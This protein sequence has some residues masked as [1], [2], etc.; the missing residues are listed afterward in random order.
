MNLLLEVCNGELKRF[1]ARLSPSKEKYIFNGHILLSIHSL[2]GLFKPLL[3]SWIESAVCVVIESIPPDS[4][5]M[6]LVLL[7]HLLIVLPGNR[8]IGLVL[9]EEVEVSHRNVVVGIGDGLNLHTF[10]SKRGAIQIVGL[11][12][13]LTD[14]ATHFGTGI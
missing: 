3:D 5:V 14:S 12:N 2:L 8:W 11:A 9:Q 13:E 7:T 10:H 4:A 6:H 1:T